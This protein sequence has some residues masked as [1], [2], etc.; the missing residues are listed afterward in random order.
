MTEFMHFFEILTIINDIVITITRANSQHY[1][2]ILVYKSPLKTNIKKTRG[3]NIIRFKA[4][5][6]IN[7]QDFSI[8]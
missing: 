3:K 1:S 8:W 2:S 6:P 5:I 7:A 4:T